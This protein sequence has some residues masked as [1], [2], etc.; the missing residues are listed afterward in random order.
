MACYRTIHNADFIFPQLQLEPA[1]AGF[2]FQLA[3]KPPGVQEA[4]AEQVA[5]FS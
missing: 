3:Y 5:W 2:F 1:S 4:I